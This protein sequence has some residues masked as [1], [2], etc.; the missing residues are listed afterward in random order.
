MTL[1]K[2]HQQFVE[3]S[4]DEETTE[5]GGIHE[6]G[7]DGLVTSSAKVFVIQTKVF[8]MTPLVLLFVLTVGH[9]TAGV[10]ELSCSDN[11]TCIDQMLRETARS[12]RQRKTVR[13]FDALTIEPLGLRQAR[14]NESPLSRFT[15]NHAFSFDWNDYTFRVTRPQD[16]SD[17]MDLEVYESRSAKGQ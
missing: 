15:K 2:N 10:V 4:I 6:R 16:R 1:D 3:G 11:A 14:A 5:E 8:K 7:T 12:L 9:V 17:V 13:L